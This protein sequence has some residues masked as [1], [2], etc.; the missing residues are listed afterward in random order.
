[1]SVSKRRFQ[2][3][4]DVVGSIWRNALLILIIIPR[5]SFNR[6]NSYINMDLEDLRFMYD[7]ANG[8]KAAD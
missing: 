5:P 2:A 8:N 3:V 4:K 1:M 7:N 6:M